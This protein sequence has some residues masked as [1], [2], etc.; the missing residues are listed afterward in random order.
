MRTKGSERKKMIGIM[1]SD[2]ERIQLL[3]LAMEARLN[4]SAYIRAKIFGYPMP[5]D[6]IAGIPESIPEP[7]STSETK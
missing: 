2:E 7:T 6:T 3:K 4:V 5:I 1:M